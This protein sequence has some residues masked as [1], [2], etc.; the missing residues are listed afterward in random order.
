MSVAIRIWTV[1][2][3]TTLV[4]SPIAAADLATPVEPLPPPPPSFYV[5]AGA[6]GVFFQP[7]AQPEAGG[8]LRI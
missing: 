4:V 6:V 7:N 3:I 5:H 2:F 1:A 8:L